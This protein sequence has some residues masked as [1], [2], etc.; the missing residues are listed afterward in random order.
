MSEYD[1]VFVVVFLSSSVKLV[2]PRWVRRTPGGV[3]NLE[4]LQSQLQELST[5][6]EAAFLGA[7]DADVLENLRVSFLGK[8]G[9]LTTILR[10]MGKLPKEARP[11]AGKIS[12]S[13]RDRMQTFLED[14]K[15]RIAKVAREAEF[16]TR[17]DN[18]LPGRKQRRGRRHI[19]T[20]TANDILDVLSTLGFQPAEGP[21]VEHDFYNFEALNMPADHPARDMQD[22]FYVS[23]KTQSPVV[24][25]THTSPVQIRAMLELK[26]APVRVACVGRVYRCDEDKTHSPMFHQIEGLYV[27]EDVTFGDLKGTLQVFAESIFNSDSKVR[28][29]PSFF[30]FTEPSVEVDISCFMCAGSGHIKSDTCGLCKGTGWI[31]IM[32]AGMV[33][34]A[35]FAATGFDSETLSGFAFGIGVERVAMLRHRIDNIGRFFENDQR[36]LSQFYE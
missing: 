9:K 4:D 18:S 30:P 5:E 34:P 35:V 14:S 17:I 24:L 31:E 13:V 25:R 3:V 16:N 12:N 7:A 33:D 19:L 8:K 22:T 32:G 10:G 23:S 27:D 29:R 1:G 2:C 21:E 15:T 26:E 20:Q 11:E 36:F 6:A 28:L